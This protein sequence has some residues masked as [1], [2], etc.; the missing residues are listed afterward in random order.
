LDSGKR[1]EDRE[2]RRQARRGALQREQKRGDSILSPSG[3]T[4]GG[5]K[6]INLK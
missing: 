3:E 2:K 5:V 1:R 4:G 6:T